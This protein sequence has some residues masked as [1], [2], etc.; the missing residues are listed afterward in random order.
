MQRL[1]WG[2]MVQ[3]V[4]SR[5]VDDVW[6]RACRVIADLSRYVT[7]L[8]QSSTLYARLA[9]CYFIVCSQVQSWTSS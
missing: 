6:T 7:H 3:D 8:R 9:T 4:I 5:K 1:Q 2:A